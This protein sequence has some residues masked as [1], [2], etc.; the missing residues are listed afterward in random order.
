MKSKIVNSPKK[1][2]DNYFLQGNL[3]ESQSSIV[4][5]T[6]KVEQNTK[7]SGTILH[8]KEEAISIYGYKIGRHLNDFYKSAFTLFEGDILCHQP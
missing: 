3:V 7:F 5:V 8:I 6:G 4:I 1:Q 2:P